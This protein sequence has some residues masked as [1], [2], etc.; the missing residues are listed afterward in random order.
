M[1]QHPSG[2]VLVAIPLL[3]E[4]IPAV[5]ADLIQQVAMRVGNL[6]DVRGVDDDLASVGNGRLHLVHALGCRPDV[7]IHM[8]H[9]REHTP[10]RPLDPDDVALGRE[11]GRGRI[12]FF[13]C[14]DVEAGKVGHGGLADRS[15]PVPAPGACPPPGALDTTMLRHSFGRSIML[16]ARSITA[17]TGVYFVPITLWLVITAPSQWVKL[18]TS[19]PLIPGK[20]YL[21]PPEKPTTSCGNVGPQTTNRS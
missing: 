17:R 11:I 13:G 7:I 15:E 5:V 18:I 9:D 1:R 16:A 19:G 6:G 12:G 2:N 3:E 20:K 14:A 10:E 8:G 4:V 21:L